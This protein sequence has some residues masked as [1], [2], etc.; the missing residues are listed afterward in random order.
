MGSKRLLTTSHWDSTTHSPLICYQHPLGFWITFLSSFLSSFTYLQ[1][2]SSFQARQTV[3]CVNK[4]LVNYPKRN[5]LLGK[6]EITS[7]I[8]LCLDITLLKLHMQMA[9]MPPCLDGLGTQQLRKVHSPLSCFQLER[10]W[11]VIWLIPFKRWDQETGHLDHESTTLIHHPW[12][13]L[14][15]HLTAKTPHI[16]IPLTSTKETTQKE[17]LHCKLFG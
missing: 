9:S 17:D 14:G 11:W 7:P 6:N 15:S 13:L 10:H 16:H 12:L 8:H 4:N 2:S 3:L 1:V 5:R